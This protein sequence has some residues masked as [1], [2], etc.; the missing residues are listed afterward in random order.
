MRIVEINKRESDFVV[1]WTQ[2]IQ[3]VREKAFSD[4]GEAES[5]ANSKVSKRGYILS[6]LD[7][8]PE[9]LAAH[10]ARQ[11]RAKALMQ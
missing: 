5:F 11:A 1:S 6:T 4:R 9:Q 10:E 8:T 3:P 7:M 2:G